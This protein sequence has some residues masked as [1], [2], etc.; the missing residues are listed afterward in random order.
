[1]IGNSVPVNFSYALAQAIA[2]DLFDCQQTAAN[3]LAQTE[4]FIQP[5]LAL[6]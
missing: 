2:T 3:N 4:D 1:M 6:S 5:S